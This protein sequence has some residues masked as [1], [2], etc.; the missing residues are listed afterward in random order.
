MSLV[1]CMASCLYVKNDVSTCDTRSKSVAR[2]SLLPPNTQCIV[3]ICWNILVSV[4]PI[5]VLKI[6]VICIRTLPIK[7]LLS[8]HRKAKD[9][10]CFFSA[11]IFH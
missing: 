2:H 1:L 5:L 6:R 8:F 10:N 3:Y 7:F 4:G 9:I 11:L